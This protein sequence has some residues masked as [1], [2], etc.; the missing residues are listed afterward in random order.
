[1]EK[2]QEKRGKK[3]IIPQPH[4]HSAPNERPVDTVEYHPIFSFFK[5]LSFLLLSL[6]YFLLAIP[7][8][9]S[10]STGFGVEIAFEFQTQTP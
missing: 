6:L 1:V 4:T 2:G 8:S 5:L 7:M 3:L 10:R 9:I